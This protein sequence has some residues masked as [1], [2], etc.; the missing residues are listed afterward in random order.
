MYTRYAG[1]DAEVGAA[2]GGEAEPGETRICKRDLL[3][4]KRDLHPVGFAVC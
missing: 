1:A 3:I 2:C 4:R